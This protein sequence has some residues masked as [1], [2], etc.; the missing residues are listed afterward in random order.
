MT[1][2]GA[3]TVGTRDADAD[4]AMSLVLSSAR[5]G[6]GI[7]ILSWAGDCLQLLAGAP[8][9]AT[10]VPLPAVVERLLAACD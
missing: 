1:I 3:P 5:G 4:T 9:G 7:I 6:G 8:A 10:P 2:T